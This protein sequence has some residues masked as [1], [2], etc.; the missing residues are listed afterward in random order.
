MRAELGRLE[1]RVA[2]AQRRQ[3]GIAPRPAEGHQQLVGVGLADDRG[4]LARARGGAGAGPG[5]AAPA[6]GPRAQ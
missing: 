5:R 4:G 1:A 2:E 6:W 3:R